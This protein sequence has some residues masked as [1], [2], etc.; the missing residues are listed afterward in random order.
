MGVDLATVLAV[1]GAVF[2]GNLLEWSIGGPDL[3]VSSLGVLGEPQG[4]LDSHNKYEG[5]A[6]ATRADLYE[7]YVAT[8]LTCRSPVTDDFAAAT[9][10]CY[11][12]LCFRLYTIW[13]RRKTTMTSSS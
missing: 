5:D 1:Y 6:S 11:S 4:I 10:T 9:T 8:F 12:C 3:R 7:A 13:A 2:D